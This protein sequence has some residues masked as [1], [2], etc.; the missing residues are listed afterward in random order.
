MWFRQNLTFIIEQCLL[1]LNDSSLCLL[2]GR[3]PLHGDL[4]DVD[5]HVRLEGGGHLLR[6]P[7]RQLPFVEP[8]L[9]E[10]SK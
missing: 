3:R 2:L 8:L 5:G 10:E 4:V 7:L 9:E 6:L 1:A